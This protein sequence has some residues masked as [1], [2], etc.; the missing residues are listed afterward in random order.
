[1][2]HAHIV[3]QHCITG[4]LGRPT[5]KHKP[6]AQVTG[7]NV[8]L[9]DPIPA[10]SAFTAIDGSQSNLASLV[11]IAWLVETCRLRSKGV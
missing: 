7:R 2:R 10:F 9:Q 5:G 4:K 11:F 1:M 6:I 8:S 3:M